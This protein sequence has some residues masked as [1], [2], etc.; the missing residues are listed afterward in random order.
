MVKL[1]NECII[2]QSYSQKRKRI[3]ILKKNGRRRRRRR[4]SWG[5]LDEF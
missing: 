5:K 2:K 4:R 1:I 3:F